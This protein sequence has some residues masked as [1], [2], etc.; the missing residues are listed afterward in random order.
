MTKRDQPEDE[1]EESIS[2]SSSKVS[3]YQEIDD[4]EENATETILPFPSCNLPPHKPMK[5]TS[6]DDFE[7]HYQQTHVNRC[8]TCHKNFPSGHYLD[9]HIAENHDPINQIRKE[10]GEKTVSVETVSYCQ[11]TNTS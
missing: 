6:F 2:P 10:R 4:S 8:F 5:F 11:V 1:D 9:I 7:V 3:K